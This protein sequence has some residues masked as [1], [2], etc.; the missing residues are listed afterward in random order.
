LGG[1]D[2]IPSNFVQGG[3]QDGNIFYGSLAKAGGGAGQP[4]T[5]MTIVLP[6]LS[7]YENLELRVD[8][9]APEG[10]W[11]YT[12]RDS[13][14]IIGGTTT[15]P[16]ELFCNAAGCLP[17]PGAIDSFLP[18]AY[19]GNLQSQMYSSDLN[20]VFQD[21]G[22]AIDSS[23]RSITFAFASSAGEEI[24]GIDSLRIIGDPAAPVPEPSTMFL[25]G[26]GLAG[27]IG[28]GRRRIKK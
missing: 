10:I 14:H 3:S 12:H 2:A 1:T 4:V 26:S 21:Y 22:Y 20:L 7:G 8:L 11:E 5:T 15:V 18:D 19:G 27:L 17:V 28:Y 13:L 24:V 6:D 16:P 23:L 25:L 9:A